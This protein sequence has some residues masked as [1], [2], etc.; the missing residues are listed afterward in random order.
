[1]FDKR[2]HWTQI[3]KTRR[4]QKYNL[5]GRN[6]NYAL[7]LCCRF[8]MFSNINDRDFVKL[9]D[10]KLFSLDTFEALAK[11]EAYQDVMLVCADKKVP[12]TRLLLALAIPHMGELLRKDQEEDLTLLLPQFK[13]SE[14]SNAVDEFLRSNLQVEIKSE[15]DFCDGNSAEEDTLTSL[16]K[17]NGM[18]EHGLEEHSKPGEIQRHVASDGECDRKE[19]GN[20]DSECDQKDNS[21]DV[22]CP[23][24][25]KC[26]D[27]KF[28]LQNHMLEFHNYVSKSHFVPDITKSTTCKKKR[29]WHCIQNNCGRTFKSERL[30]MVHKKR[31]RGEFKFV[32][33]LCSKKFVTRPAFDI[34]K[35][36]HRE[37]FN[38][39]CNHCQKQHVTQRG[40]LRHL[41]THGPKELS[42]TCCGKK[43]C[44]E[45]KLKAHIKD[46]QMKR[47]EKTQCKHC[48]K[49]F[50]TKK[51]LKVHVMNIHEKIRHFCDQC[52]S[53]YSVKQ[54]LLNHIHEKHEDQTQKPRTTFPCKE[55]GKGFSRPYNLCK[56]HQ[57]QDKTQL[58]TCDRCG[59]STKRAQQLHMHQVSPLDT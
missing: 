4:M 43:F 21:K 10:D 16:D 2:G 26:T 36:I 35:K 51:N 28:N 39:T 8:L 5:V 25:D 30:F 29:L 31:H 55:C 54:N 22:I 58:L 37:E 59:F 19:E 12:G 34:H 15:G 17:D 46:E 44:D 32:C 57:F 56:N 40:F 9:V 45:S 52:G 23:L 50:A 6:V 13:A 33:D 27:R 1:M 53:S 18:L 14:I 3:E 24:C 20:S 48:K 7:I 41:R 49:I 42:C 11:H 47:E 38:F